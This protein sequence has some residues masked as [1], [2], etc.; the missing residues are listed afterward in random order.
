MQQRRLIL[1]DVYSKLFQVGRTSERRVLS[2]RKI[3][4]Q[5]HPNDTCLSETK[6]NPKNQIRS[7]QVIQLWGTWSTDDWESVHS[8]SFKNIF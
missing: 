3:Q 2:R 4:L 7:Q 8:L 6:R 1:D 5:N